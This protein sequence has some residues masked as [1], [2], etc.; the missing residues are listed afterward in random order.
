[1][2]ALLGHGVKH[3]IPDVLVHVG[4]RIGNAASGQHQFDVYGELVDAFHTYVMDTAAM[5]SGDAASFMRRIAD[6][7][8]KTWREPDSG[9]W[10]PRIAPQHYTHSKVMAW[11][12]LQ[13]AATLAEDGSIHGDAARWRREAFEIRR[14]VMERGFN[15][16]RGTFIQTLDGQAVDAALLMLPLVGFIEPNDPRMLSTISVIQSELTH[17]GF[18]RRYLVDDGVEGGEGAFL[19]CNFWLAA[20]LARGGRVEDAH[21][22]FMTTLRAQNDL[23]LMA[24]EVDPPTLAALGNFPQ[25]FS[26]IGLITAALA[27]RDAALSRDVSPA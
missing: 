7:V 6:H 9:I 13:H 21:R 15:R 19:I 1:M 22:V 5:V 17:N 3:P 27:I 24:E 8:A 4:V 23:G 26:H 14:A 2:T 20:A 12:A 10:E 16:D 25:A 11:S 18:L